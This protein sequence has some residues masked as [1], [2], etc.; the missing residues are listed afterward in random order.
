[1]LLKEWKT[2]PKI[3]TVGEEVLKEL[4]MFYRKQEHREGYYISSLSGC[5]R[6]AYYEIVYPT[7][8]KDKLRKSIF[9]GE[10]IHYF[11]SYLI[12]LGGKL[13]FKKIESEVPVEYEFEGKKLVGRADIVLKDR[14][15]E[16]KTTKNLPRLPYYS[17]VLQA[18]AYAY[19]LNKKK[20]EITYIAE[21]G[22]RSFSMDTSEELFEKLKERARILHNAVK[23]SIAPEKEPTPYCNRC[24]Y[25]HIC[26]K[27]L[28]LM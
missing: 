13:M 25:Y 26:Y 11:I 16:I 18:N 7:E 6:K 19:L 23:Y 1:M 20:F 4:Y 12:N 5:L 17:H 8:E 3:S 10:A 22:V 24:P 21:H 27:Q 14:V 2:F 9:E 15:I 28:Q